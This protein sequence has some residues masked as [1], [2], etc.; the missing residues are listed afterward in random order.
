MGAERD[1]TPRP[2]PDSPLLRGSHRCPGVT[3]VP[4]W[5]Y[6]LTCEKIHDG[7]LRTAILEGERRD[8]KLI[9]RRRKLTLRRAL[10]AVL[11]PAALLALV[12]CGGDAA[13]EAV[14]DATPGT[15][16]E[17]S[18]GTQAAVVQLVSAS[19]D[20]SVG[21][22]RFVFGLM[23]SE[24]NPVR[25][26][27]VQVST[28]YLKGSALEGPKEEVDAVFRKWPVGPAG[29]YTAQLSFDTSGNWGIGVAITGPDGVVR[30]G[31]TMIQVKEASAT[32]AIGSLVPHSISKTS[33]KSATLAE[34]TSDLEPD[35]ELYKLTVA[36]A[37]DA[38]VPLMLVFASPA[39]CQS[40]TCGPQVEVV[41][42]LREKYEGKASFIHVE[43]YD[44][45]QEIQGDL[46]RARISSTLTEWN[47]P[48]EP[49]TF[50]VDSDGLLHA[51]FEA[52]ATGEELEEALVE[53]LP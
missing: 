6:R 33:G 13:T 35:P 45:P 44:N 41:K 32:P 34:I 23:D 8:M 25:E 48:S 29:I 2:E 10:W 47:L 43:V 31:T 21:G 51:K 4:Y 52:F 50:I 36:D 46:S 20:L 37:I 27:D 28:F 16:L 49:W 53:V 38:G 14:A 40:A 42:E 39:Y 3:K 17:A 26:A 18:A 24:S 7:P 11:L 30:R 1:T 9:S 19:S 22:N 5:R 15:A 12:V